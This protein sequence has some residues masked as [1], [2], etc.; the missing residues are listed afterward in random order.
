MLRKRAASSRI[1]NPRGPVLGLFERNAMRLSQLEE[2]LFPVEQH[3]VFVV[4]RDESGERRL[5]AR[6]KKAIVN[7]ASQRVLGIVSREY[8]LVTN[9]E[10]LE[11]AYQCCR[12]VFPNTNAAEW[13]VNATDAPST[14][15]YCRIDLTHRTAAL[16]FGDVRPGQ[17]PEAFGPVSRG[18]NRYNGVPALAFAIGIYPNVRSHGLN[19]PR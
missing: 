9:P 2:V 13:D 8:R 19:G 3:P 6:D 16:D 7:V 11:W 12:S 18:T 10:A 17:R 14:G 1:P 4:V 15:G 5:P